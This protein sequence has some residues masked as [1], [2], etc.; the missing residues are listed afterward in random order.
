[1]S[2][3]RVPTHVAFSDESSHNQGRYRGLGLLTLENSN[4]ESTKTGVAD[5][6]KSSGVHEI[7]WQKVRNA[8]GRFAALKL[9]EYALD[10]IRTGWFRV[11]VLTWDV[12][13]QRHSITGRDDIAN[14][15]R[16]YYHLFRNVLK[17]R[18]PDDAVWHLY[19]DE[20]NAMDWD[21]VGEILG[22]A[23]TR[24]EVIGDLFSKRSFK[25]S[26]KRDFRIEQIIPS[27]SHM[28]PLVQ[29][30]DLF[31]GI[32]VYS[33]AS[34]DVFNE[35]CHVNPSTETLFPLSVTDGSAI[36]RTDNERCTVLREFEGTSRRHRLNVSLRASK[37]LR[38]R[39][40]AERI[41]FW[42]YEPQHS[43]DKAPVKT[44][45]SRV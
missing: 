39:N 6:L 29:L 34:F 24:R 4:L 11:D 18:W 16:M 20:N 14:L 42:W 41:N 28:E 12:Q 38:S 32:G 9:F 36:V 5:L 13:D 43:K 2:S 44:R 10:A 30:A 37:G 15:H 1:M 3:S 19:P 45:D 17:N 25:A 40:P 27:Q 33:R 7:K 8:R 21:S 31:V 26:L 22:N 23:S 35:W